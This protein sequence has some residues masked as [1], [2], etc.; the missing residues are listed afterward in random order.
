MNGTPFGDLSHH[1]QNTRQDKGEDMPGPWSRRT[2]VVSVALVAICAVTLSSFG[3]KRVAQAIGSTLS[4]IRGGRRTAMLS[5][6]SS[7]PCGGTLLVDGG[8]NEIIGG[9][10]YVSQISQ[11]EDEVSKG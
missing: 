1:T 5:F 8:C 6:A 10:D 4:S 7:S 2:L 11:L 3:S 9:A